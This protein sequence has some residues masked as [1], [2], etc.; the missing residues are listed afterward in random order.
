VLI[1]RTSVPSAFAV[2][3]LLS[4]PSTWRTKASLVPSGE[5]AGCAASVR[6]RLSVFADPS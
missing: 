6:T 5:N 3:S 1:C 2:K 4:P